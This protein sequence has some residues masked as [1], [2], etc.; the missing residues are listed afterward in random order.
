MRTRRCTAPST[1]TT[2]THIFKAN[3]FPGVVAR[4]PDGVVFNSRD[5]L[6]VR[7]A[8]DITETSHP[9]FVHLP[10]HGYYQYSDAFAD[11]LVNQYERN[12]DFFADARRR[13]YEMNHP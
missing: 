4:L 9:E 6:T 3:S 5:M 13:Y 2:L 11:W 12:D 1:G 10:R 7:R 8:H